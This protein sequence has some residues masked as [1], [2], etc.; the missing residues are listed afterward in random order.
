MAGPLIDGRS[1]S[2]SR[3]LGR[4]RAR[5]R[6]SRRSSPDCP[7]RRIL[8]DYQTISSDGLIQTDSLMANLRLL[9]PSDE[10]TSELFYHEM[11]YV[12]HRIYLKRAPELFTMKCYM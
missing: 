7:F 4:C 10:R 12:T 8:P 1:S 3:L 11:L 6:I 5:G 9:Y 2:P